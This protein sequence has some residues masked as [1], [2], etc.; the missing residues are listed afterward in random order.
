MPCTQI[1]NDQISEKSSASYNIPNMIKLPIIKQTLID[2]ETLLKQM[3][4]AARTSELSWFNAL[5]TKFSAWNWQKYIHIY[6]IV[7]E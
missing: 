6:I 2:R 4:A 1:L 7:W 3:Q 5:V